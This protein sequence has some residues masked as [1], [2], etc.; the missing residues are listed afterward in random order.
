MA[1]GGTLSPYTATIELDPANPAAFALFEVVDHSS[2]GGSGSSGAGNTSFLPI[3]ED[4]PSLLGLAGADGDDELRRVSAT[5]VDSRFENVIVAV[6]HADAHPL[7]GSGGQ[8]EKAVL[9]TVGESTVLGFLY[10]QEVDEKTKRMKVLSPVP[11]RVP[12]GRALVVG[13]WPGAMFLT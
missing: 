13:K 7:G 9:K 1:S 10:V 3:G 11:G 5:E 2:S 6:V 8:A 12:Q 4:D